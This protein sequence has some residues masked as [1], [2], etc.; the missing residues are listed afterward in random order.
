MNIKFENSLQSLGLTAADVS[1]SIREKI[2]QFYA[3]KEKYDNSLEELKSYDGDDK[4]EVART[5]ESVGNMI[6]EMDE[7]LVVKIT[8]WNEKKDQYAQSA[9][10]L[11]AAR[12]DKKKLGAIANATIPVPA[13][14]GASGQSAPAAPVVASAA[15]AA[16]AAQAA[17]TDGN[18]IVVEAVEEKKESGWGWLEGIAAVAVTLVTLGL[19]SNAMKKK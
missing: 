1:H 3:A 4:D 8:K 11:Q 14:G 16:L 18:P 10:K 5:V 17:G 2:N 15:H 9:A 19:L 6:Q 13:Q 12:E 7:E